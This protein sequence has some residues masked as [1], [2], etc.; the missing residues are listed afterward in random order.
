MNKVTCKGKLALKP[1]RNATQKPYHHPKTMT[2]TKLKLQ[3]PPME[4]KF[5][6]GEGL[7]IDIN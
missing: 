1:I 4:V 2:E 6:I 5:S 7:I 3:H